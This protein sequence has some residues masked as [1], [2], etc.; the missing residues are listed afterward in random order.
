MIGAMAEPAGG[1]LRPGGMLRRI[2][3]VSAFAA[4]FT[5]AAPTARVFAYADGSG[6]LATGLCS[7]NE[8]L[9]KG[10]PIPTPTVAA[11]PTALLL[12][13]GAAV[14]LAGI[15]AWAFGRRPR[16]NRPSRSGR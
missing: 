10:V 14:L 6:G 1:G 9:A 11:P 15:S 4:L 5:L 3:T 13:I 8:L 2:L 16:G 12:A 7:G